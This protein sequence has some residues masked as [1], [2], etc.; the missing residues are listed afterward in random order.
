MLYDSALLS[1]VYLHAY[2]ASGDP[3]FRRIVEETLNYVLREMTSPEGGFYSTQDADSEGEEGKFFV[4][5]PDEVDALLGSGDGP[6]FRAYFDVT[7]AGNASTGSAHGFERKNILHVDHSLEEV[8]AGLSVTPERLSEAIERGKRILFEARE[9]RVK[10]G[11]DDKI[12]TA[13]NGLMLASMAE[14]GAVLQR[15]DYVQAAAQA[16][17]FILTRLRDGNGRL[18]RSYKDGQS[19]F[20]AYL[21]D[22]AYLAD[23]LLALYQATFDVRWLEEA[24]ALADEMLARFW[25]EESGGFF[26]TASDHADQSLIIRPKNITDNA[27]PSGNAVAASVLLQ[28]SVLSGPSTDSEPGATYHR[29]AVETLRLLGGAMARHPRA[30]GQALSALDVYLASTKE[31]VIVGDPQEAVTQALLETVHGRYLP[32]KLLVVASPDQVEELSQRIPLLAGRTQ[33]EGAASAYVC[34]N[35]ACQLP[36][37]EPEALLK[38]L[39]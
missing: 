7:E 26:D 22:H 11:R 21:E 36:V 18:L 16:A 30:F 5:T 9:E 15:P 25:D 6:M 12:L 14:A 39:G 20:D 13:W 27:I 29:H 3:F 31:I 23:G 33:I 24:R 38:L 19:K 28:L 32:N 10:P 35:Y 2:Q 8:A 37:T 1:R 34:E 17:D 4:W